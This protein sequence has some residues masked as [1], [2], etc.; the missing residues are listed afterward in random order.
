MIL[1]FAFT[2]SGC[3]SDYDITELIHI[4][5]IGVDK[6]EDGKPIIT[7]Q[8]ANIKSAPG[9]ADNEENKE[10]K[11][12]IITFRGNTFSDTL[13]ALSSILPRMPSFAHVK[14]IIFSK[15]FAEDGIYSVIS[16]VLRHADFRG[17]AYI[18]VVNNGT[19][20]EFIKQNNPTFEYLPYRYIESQATLSKYSRYYSKA[21]IYEF[22]NRLNSNS[23]SSYAILGGINKNHDLNNAH[24]LQE[25]DSYYAGEMPRRGDTNPV[26]LLGTALFYKDKYIGKLTAEDSMIVSVI[27]GDFRKTSVVIPDPNEPEL[28]V[29][30][31]VV[32]KRPATISVKMENDKVKINV[33]LLLEGEAINT[34]SKINY[35]TPE[36]RRQLEEAFTEHMTARL[37]KM[38]KKTQEIGADPIGLGYYNR[39][40]YK[41]YQEFAK[42]DWISLYKNAE[43]TGKTVLK[44]RS[45]GLSWNKTEEKNEVDKTE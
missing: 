5:I 39:A 16:P 17:N 1:F 20:E 42:S 22:Y 3:N 11:L 29:S 37:L 19:A 13:D 7:Y 35:D 33:E 6:G 21:T 43:I 32:L 26:E 45:S 40:N 24:S 10:P 14:A 44:I 25:G 12:N 41:N 34:P 4:A 28:Y 36:N 38:L 27:K 23:S 31:I 15:E 30:C 9:I 2:L 8:I 18:I